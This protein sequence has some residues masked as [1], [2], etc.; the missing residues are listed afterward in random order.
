MPS[1]DSFDEGQVNNVLA[2]MSRDANPENTIKGLSDD[3]LDVAMKYT[4]KGLETGENSN[5]YLRFHEA[6]FNKGGLGP[7]IRALVKEKKQ[8]GVDDKN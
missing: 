2:E 3:Q 5:T 4:Y 1:F 7:I 6:I 8:G